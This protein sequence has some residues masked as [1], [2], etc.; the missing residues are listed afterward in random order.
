MK[1]HDS[2]V[3]T[4]REKRHIYEVKVVNVLKKLKN[5]NNVLTQ[6]HTH[7]QTDCAHTQAALHCLEFPQLYLP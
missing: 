4:L 3:K 6:R 5:N 7:T 2:G 1:H